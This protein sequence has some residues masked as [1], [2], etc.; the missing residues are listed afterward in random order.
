MDRA[1]R[2]NSVSRR[3]FIG[4]SAILAATA[5]SAA[6]AGCA[7]KTGSS[8]SDT[9]FSTSEEVLHEAIPS[10]EGFEPNYWPS[11]GKPA[12]VANSIDDVSKTEDYD[13]V[14]CGCGFAGANAAA[15]AAENGAKVAVLEKRSTFGAN[16]Y[17]I[18]AIGDRVHKAAGI[19]INIDEF[20]SDM[21]ATA[22]GYRANESLIRNFVKRSGEAMDW[23][24]D[25]LEGKVTPPVIGTTEA[26]IGGITW[27]PSD[28]SFPID[29]TAG[30]I[31]HILEYAE[32]F[33]STDIFYDTPACQLVQSSDGSIEGVIAFRD[34]EYVRYNAS[35]GVILATGGYEHSKE[36][37]QKCLRP[38]DLMCRA[39]LNMNT[40]NTGD[41]HEMGLSVGGFEDEYPHCSCTDP[42][43]T[44]NHTFFG[45]SMNSFLRVNDLGKRFM[46]EGIP[47][48]Y[49]ANSIGNQIGAHCWTLTDGN[50]LDH[51]AKISADSPYTPEEQLETLEADCYKAD[52]LEDL[53]RQIN[54]NYDAL[55]ETIDRYNSLCEAGED[56]D[57]GTPAFFM[58]TVKNP[59]FYAVDE[60]IVH[61]ATVNGLQV[62]QNSAVL[63]LKDR[64]PIPNLYAIGN[65]S[66]SMFATTY[67]HHISAV[68]LGRC[69][70]MGYVVSRILTG[71]EEAI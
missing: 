30:L 4:G 25:I 37:L 26:K 13:I 21:M 59:P 64:A 41:G 61:L 70:T 34:G 43:G 14:I 28:V 35:K 40:E 50:V 71:A 11:E 19:E 53:A 51:L 24:L 62:D 33:G 23:M 5:A 8:Q 9:T 6:L 38:R 7:P 54:V 15:S 36:R 27:W 39:W 20:V 17:N 63:S 49:R 48:D 68:S 44:P 18:A 56:T 3:T 2:T 46:N 65:T 42:S 47:F 1:K 55:K 12:F 16:G 58:S 69:L 52:S 32:S 31:P 60:G 66:G 45:A 67:P 10:C 22:G 29:Q 57:F